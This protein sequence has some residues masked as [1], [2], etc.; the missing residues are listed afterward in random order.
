MEGVNY[1]SDERVFLFSYCFVEGESLSSYEKRRCKSDCFDCSIYQFHIFIDWVQALI[2]SP[3]RE[4]AAQTEKQILAIGD[5]ISIQ[6]HACIGGKSVGED[7]RKLE[8]GFPDVYGTP[9][10]VC[11]IKRRTV[12]TRAIKLC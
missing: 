6:A 7:I 4:L 2:L 1:L 3:T 8:N 9:G 10:R 12:R 5:F 11:M